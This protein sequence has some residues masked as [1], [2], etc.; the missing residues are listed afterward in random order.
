MLRKVFQPCDP[1]PPRRPI[2]LATVDCDIDAEPEQPAMKRATQPS[3]QGLEKSQKTGHPAGSL[4]DQK[5]IYCLDEIIGSD[6][7]FDGRGDDRDDQAFGLTCFN[8]DTS[9]PALLLSHTETV[10]EG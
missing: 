3:D 4:A 8:S 1:D 6:K 5:G 2:Y 9:T 10:V 7:Q